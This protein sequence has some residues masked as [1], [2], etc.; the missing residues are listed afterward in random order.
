MVTFAGFTAFAVGGTEEQCVFPFRYNGV[1]YNECTKVEDNKPWCSNM[2][3]ENDDHV[4]GQ[5]TYCPLFPGSSHLIS[6]LMRCVTELRETFL[7]L[8]TA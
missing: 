2:T 8:H 1:L 6:M 7:K 3:D 4:V 5:W